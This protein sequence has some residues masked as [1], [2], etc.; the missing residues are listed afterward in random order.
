MINTAATDPLWEE[1][2]EYTARNS[3]SGYERRILWDWIRSCHGVHNTA[4]PGYPPRPAC[5]Q[6][7]PSDARGLDWELTED[8][9]EIARDE[10]NAY[11]KP[12]IGYGNHSPEQA[13]M[14]SSRRT[15]PDLTGSRTRR[16]ERE[17]FHLWE[18]IW[19]EGLGSEARE[20]VDE[21]R[22]DETPFEW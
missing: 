19:Q 8:M 5:P 10:R 14:N 7:D 2:R 16:L 1:F 3:L 21:R 20:F 4:G 9:K 18:F 13:A 6:M 12:Y 11:L 17:L 15:T 22:S